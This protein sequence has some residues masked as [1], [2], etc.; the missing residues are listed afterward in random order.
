MKYA[1]IAIVLDA[2]DE[3]QL[4]SLLKGYDEAL[5]DQVAEQLAKAIMAAYPAN[6]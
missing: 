6:P 3:D 2:Q 5:N 4:H 1:T